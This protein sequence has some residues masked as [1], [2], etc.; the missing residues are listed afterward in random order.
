V[1]ATVDGAGSLL[2][3]PAFV[4][5]VILPVV[6]KRVAAPPASTSAVDLRRRRHD[7]RLVAEIV[8]GPSSRV[9][10]KL[11]PD[12]RAGATYAA[13]LLDGTPV[14]DERAGQALEALSVGYGARPPGLN[15][16][17]A[18]ATMRRAVFPFRTYPTPEWPE[19]V[20]VMVAAAER[21][22]R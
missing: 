10:A 9:F 1:T 18:V 19:R 21:A 22:L 15:W 2:E 17:L 20:E 3:D 8:F 12:A 13:H 11:Y 5:S 14:G 4:R 16:H 6:S 7:G